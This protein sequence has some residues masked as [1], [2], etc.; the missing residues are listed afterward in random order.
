[1]ILERI[2]NMNRLEEIK[3]EK[4]ELR[5]ALDSKDCDLNEI[6]SKLN[7]LEAEEFEIRKKQ[8]ICG[9][10]DGGE[11]IGKDKGKDNNDMNNCDVVDSVEYRKAFAQ[12]VASGKLIPAEVRSSIKTSDAG[13][14]IPATIMGKIVEKL[15][16][17]GGIYGMVT[18]TAY[19]AGVT[20][21]TSTALPVAE[22]VAEGGSTD[23][24]KKN[25]GTITFAGNKVRVAVSVSLELSVQ[26]LEVFEANLADNV[27]NAMIKAFDIAIINGSGIGCPKG[28]LTETPVETVTAAK[29]N[30]E[31]LNNIEGAI[32]SAYDDNAVIVMSKK[33]LFALRS[34][35]DATG[36]VAIETVDGKPVYSLLGRR[37]VISPTMPDYSRAEAGDVI[38][39]AVDLSQYILNFNYQIKVS[40]REDWDT[41]DQ[42]MK[43]VAVAD[44][45]LVDAN[46]LVFVAKA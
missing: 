36:V 9:R 22:W 3:K 31:L 32:P 1:M 7:K 12:Y 17:Y 15:E 38:A 28:I 21:P 24:K 37:V 45:K 25:Y 33:T 42:Q 4:M 8:A 16:G 30:Y 19:P 6:E 13:A 11:N 10:L 39:F 2:L 34:L 26:A 35:K 41:E 18:H 40:R 46:G 43:A 5:K 44:G 14:V 23:N 29:L 20:I 27:A